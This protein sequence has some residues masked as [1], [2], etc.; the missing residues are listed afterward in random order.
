VRTNIDFFAMKT[1]ENAIFAEFFLG[2]QATE[3]SFQQKKQIT[4]HKLNITNQYFYEHTSW[5]IYDYNNDNK[6][7]STKKSDRY[8]PNHKIS[9]P[10]SHLP[11]S[12][13]HYRSQNSHI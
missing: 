7:F 12:S 13:H 3:E 6:T 8:D 10:R 9:N 4:K 1:I 5:F 11:T 2:S